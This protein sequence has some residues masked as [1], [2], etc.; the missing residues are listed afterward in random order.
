[1]C[2]TLQLIDLINQ[3]PQPVYF[4][5]ALRVICPGTIYTI[6]K[7][8]AEKTDIVFYAPNKDE[9]RLSRIVHFQRREAIVNTLYKK[10]NEQVTT[11]L[12]FSKAMTANILAPL[13]VLAVFYA[14]SRIGRKKQTSVGVAPNYGEAELFT[15]CVKIE[16]ELKRAVTSEHLASIRRM[17]ENFKAMYGHTIQGKYDYTALLMLYRIKAEELC[18]EAVSENEHFCVSKDGRLLMDVML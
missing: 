16:I 14:L 7:V 17:L 8:E 1:M 15:A 4:E 3:Q 11:A 12:P 18:P 2:S 13:F 9:Y 10:L 5:P 6:W